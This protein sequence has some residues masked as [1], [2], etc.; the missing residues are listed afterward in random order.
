MAF[1]FNTEAS[2]KKPYFFISYEIT[3]DS[4][5]RDAGGTPD[6]FMSLMTEALMKEFPCV[7]FNTIA[8]VRTLLEHERQL[9]LLG[10]GNEEAAKNIGAS[11]GAD[12]LISLQIKSFPND[13]YSFK[14]SCI[15]INSSSKTKDFAKTIAMATGNNLSNKNSFY[16]VLEGITERIIDQLSNYEICPYTG[17]VN[18]KIAQKKETE[19]ET[20]YEVYCSKQDRKYSKTSKLN[21]TSN[22]IWTLEKQQKEA[23]DGTVNYTMA[24]LT[25]TEETDECYQCAPMITGARTYTAKA[26]ATLKIK[27]NVSKKSIRENENVPDA[28]IRIKFLEDG[29]YLLLVKAASEAGDLQT[30]KE[31]KASGD[32]QTFSKPTEKTSNKSD[33]GIRETLGPFPGNGKEK[34][35]QEKQT[36]EKTDPVTKEK[37]TITF[38]FNL[39]RE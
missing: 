38:D 13:F 12:Y 35:L 32:C 5:S 2:S 1:V 30:L 33:I 20:A 34:V 18:V 21:K 37:T 22:A 29:T 36:I 23:A 3:G 14:V 8:A 17:F 28:Y 15:D 24:E 4:S 19:E 10:T 31:E 11:M 9:Q 25:E 6:V 26:E 16:N 39:R 27:G 7:Q